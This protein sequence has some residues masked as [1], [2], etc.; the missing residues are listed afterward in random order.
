M[1][2]IYVCRMAVKIS[3]CNK[4]C[5]RA[6]TYVQ[7]NEKLSYLIATNKLNRSSLLV[8]MSYNIFLTNFWPFLQPLSIGK[9]KQ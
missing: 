9:A 6:S 1:K 7:Y 8:F 5:L 2:P 3:F 4:F